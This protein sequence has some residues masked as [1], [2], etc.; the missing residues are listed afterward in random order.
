[1]AARLSALHAGRPLPSGI[2]L[3]LNSVRG[4][5]EPRGLVGLEGLGKLKKS[6]YYNVYM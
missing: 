3:V 6:K 2:F 4:C 5:V 1:M